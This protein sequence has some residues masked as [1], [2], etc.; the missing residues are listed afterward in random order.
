M[1]NADVRA[2]SD[3]NNKTS[4]NNEIHCPRRRSQLFLPRRGQPC[5]Y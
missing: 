2:I 5:A 3:Q 1:I 4:L